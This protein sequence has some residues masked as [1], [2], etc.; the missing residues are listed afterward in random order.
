MGN[1]RYVT[2][3]AGFW[4]RTVNV[5]ITCRVWHHDASNSSNGLPVISGS[6]A[7]HWN[8]EKFLAEPRP[9]GFS[10]KTWEGWEKANFLG[11]R[12]G[13][14]PWQGP[15]ATSPFFIFFNISSFFDSLLSL[16]NK[17]AMKPW[18]YQWLKRLSSHEFVSYSCK[19]CSNYSVHFFS[20]TKRK[21]NIPYK[22]NVLQCSCT[23]CN[24]LGACFWDE[25]LIAYY[26]TISTISL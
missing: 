8:N 23:V 21:K 5:S 15:S 20:I 10:L 9:Q 14:E 16:Y 3:W 7:T 4:L 22:G 18:K 13:G 26:N 25:G 19:S 11:K 24:E 2:P 12:P 1:R 17:V 6:H